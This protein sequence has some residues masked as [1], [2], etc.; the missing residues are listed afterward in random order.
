MRKLILILALLTLTACIRD[1]SVRPIDS[2]ATYGAEQF[3][4][5]LTAV[6]EE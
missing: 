3:H 4:L 5:Q 1:P 6:A 2:T